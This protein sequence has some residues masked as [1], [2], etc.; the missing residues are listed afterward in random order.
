LN[1]II[2]I[3]WLICFAYL[4]WISILFVSWMR[5]Q[6]TKQNTKE[7]NIDTPISFS[8]V[9]AIRNESENLHDLLKSIAQLKFPHHLFELILVDDHSKD[10]S[11]QIIE[12]FKIVN[13]HITIQYHALNTNETGKKSALYK[14][15]KLCKNKIIITTDGDIEVPKNWLELSAKAFQS[16]E[17]MMV[18]GG[19]KIN[20]P[21][22]FI[23]HF[24]ALELLSLI[25][26]GA[27]AAGLQHPIMS[28]GANIS[29]RK[30]ILEFIGYDHLK[31]NT[32]S[33]DDMFLMLEAK[34]KFGAKSIMFLKDSTHFV[35]TVAITNWNELINQR[36]RW[37]SKSAHYKNSFL[38]ATSWIVFL[39]NLL[40]PILVVLSVFLPE[41][42]RILWPIWLLK[43]MIDYIFLFNASQFTSQKYLMKN[44]FLMALIYPFFIS[45]TAIAGQFSTFK[46]KGRS[47]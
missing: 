1:T 7:T 15:Y 45:Y 14:G 20:K 23:G 28:N 47:Y 36:I 44:Y 27:G 42:L 30:D 32:P 5:K 29:F 10:N 6:N 4:S 38:I 37:V 22:N 18:L 8:I 46:W 9:V 41:I 34:R 35:N 12:Q 43:V 33:G 39:Q 19:V 21:S 2:T 25:A 3:S 26:S 31:P 24:Q 11:K 16:S 17:I 13:P 40:L